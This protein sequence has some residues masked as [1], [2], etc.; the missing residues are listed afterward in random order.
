MIE[1]YTIKFY[2]TVT[3]DELRKKLETMTDYDPAELD[4]L[5]KM[6]E[7]RGQHRTA[8]LLQQFWVIQTITKSL[9]TQGSEAYSIRRTFARGIKLILNRA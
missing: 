6:R 9:L 1:R 4:R 7:I 3:Q 2:P 5:H 8:Y